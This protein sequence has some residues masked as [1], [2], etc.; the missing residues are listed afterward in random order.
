MIK[1]KSSYLF[2]DQRTDRRNQLRDV[3]T[4]KDLLNDIFMT[5]LP[6]PK[7]SWRRGK[8][9]TSTVTLGGRHNK[10]ENKM[11]TLEMTTMHPR[12][13]HIGAC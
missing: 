12:C 5:R 10:I 4:L 11:L 9:Y 2:E 6:K 7:I 13:R 1:T 8:Q 3:A